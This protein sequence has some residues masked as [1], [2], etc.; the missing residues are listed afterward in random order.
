MEARK[1]FEEA[2]GSIVRGSK[3]VGSQH[4]TVHC[5][6]IRGRWTKPEIKEEKIEKKGNERA[7]RAKI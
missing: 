4:A 2:E 5:R 1:S 6:R 3:E 7:L